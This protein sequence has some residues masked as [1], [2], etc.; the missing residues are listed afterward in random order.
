MHLHKRVLAQ[1]HLAVAG[2]LLIGLAT[3]H[4]SAATKEYEVKAAFLFHFTQFV[5]WP[6]STFADADAPFCIGVLGDDPFGTTL[7][8]IVKDETVHKHKI[9]IKRSHDAADLKGCQ[10]L[11]VSNSEKDHLQQILSSL[12]ESS[13]LT[14]GESDGFTRQDGIINFYLD[15]KKVRFEIKPDAAKR[16]GLK[17]SSQLLGLGRI[18]R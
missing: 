12:N 13:I 11:F 14:V 6:D 8:Q 9:S 18:V 17:I 7:D 2:V 3:S 10:I 16:R 4:A 1:V 15:E 5:E